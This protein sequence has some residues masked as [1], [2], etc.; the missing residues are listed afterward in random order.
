[1]NFEE[2]GTVEM[3]EETHE[4]MQTPEKGIKEE[5]TKFR[6]KLDDFL[7][8]VS[9]MFHVSL[10]MDCLSRSTTEPIPMG[11][12]ILPKTSDLQ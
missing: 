9:K 11:A 12:G 10:P 4:R 1:V 2:V 3:A 5:F 7:Y 6:K 8:K